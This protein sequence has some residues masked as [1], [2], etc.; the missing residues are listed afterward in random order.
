MPSIKTNIL[1]NGIN[2]ATS[3][4]FP[5]I[6]FPYAARVL[7]P[8]GIGTINFLNGIISYI[9]LFTSLGIPMYAVKEIAK[10]RDNIK[11]RDKVTVEILILS[12]ALS[13]L[14]YIGVWILAR[15][16]QEVHEQ[17]TVFYILSLSIVFNTVGV[18]WFYQG[19]E[20]FKFI[21]V[22]AIVI[23]TLAAAAL[24]I[25]VKSPFDLVAYAF[26]IVGSTVGNN[27]INF[28]HLRTHITFPNIREL[29]IIH[30]IKPTLVWF[31]FN[32]IVS[33]YLNLNAV[34]LGFVCEEIEVGYFTA[35]SRITYIA[36]SLITSLGT[37]LL[38]RC[39][40]LLAND[41]R[42]EFSVVIRKSLHLTIGLALPIVCGL[43]LL[44]PLIT[45]VFC[46]ENFLQS[47]SVLTITA[48]IILFVGL[49][50]VTGFQILYPM[51]RTRIV[52][53]SVGVG[54]IVS[55]LMNFIL[56]PKYG[57]IGA[58]V[59]LMLAELSVLSVQLIC[60]R[61]FFPFKVRTLIN[62]NIL[63]STL[64]MA[65][66]IILMLLIPLPTILQLSSCII[67]GM[68]VYGSVLYMLHDEQFVEIVVPI[69]NRLKFI[70][71]L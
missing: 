53:C 2:T 67:A 17:A 9:V 24:F 14:G 42:E 28:I 12:F 62:T 11:E 60:G 31:V 32:L 64:V 3:L 34:M 39:T 61:S 18:N 54:A 55:L 48:P 57:A 29:R 15:Y 7:L 35:G 16:V 22:R 68:L 50:H 21:T 47:I 1:L 46:G 70:K 26:I 52:L 56:L 59:S 66:C 44:S 27:I 8:E 33:V 19:I 4:L 10:C 36:M 71:P 6:T 20:D 45:V 25:F 23:R 30:H 43:M 13:I 65:V 40:N 49:A 63:V 41:N 37:V 51:N 69:I 58:S 38:P 5:I